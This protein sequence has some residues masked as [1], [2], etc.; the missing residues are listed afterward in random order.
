MKILNA[1]TLILF[2]AYVHLK[3]PTV[4]LNSIG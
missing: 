4:M 3:V 2:P 1:D